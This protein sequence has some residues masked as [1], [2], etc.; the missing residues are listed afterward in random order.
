MFATLQREMGSLER[1]SNRVHI[2]GMVNT[3]LGFKQAAPVIN[4]CSEWLVD[5]LGPRSASLN[6]PWA[7][8]WKSR[9]TS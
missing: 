1:I 2:L 4:G 6:C 8:R 7:V 5:V 3:A 9:P